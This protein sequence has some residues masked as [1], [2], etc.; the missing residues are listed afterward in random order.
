[1]GGGGLE[2]WRWWWRRQL[3]GLADSKMYGGGSDG[4]WL[5]INWL[6]VVIEAMIETIS[7]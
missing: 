4:G 1:M 7:L 5:V 2:W 3:R 6:M